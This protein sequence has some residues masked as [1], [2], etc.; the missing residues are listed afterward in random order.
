MD[1]AGLA[2]AH[3]PLPLSLAARDALRRIAWPRGRTPRRAPAGRRP[4]GTLATLHLV[5]GAA[6]D[7]AVHAALEV[8]R[9]FRLR[10]ERVLLVDAGRRIDLHAVFERDPRW[11]FGEVLRGAL[12]L[13]GVVQETGYPGL[14]LLAR[15]A[16]GAEDWSRLA[17]LLDEAAPHFSRVVLALDP[18][19]PRA[20]GEA[21]AGRLVEGWWAGCG[22]L[23]RAA[24]ALAERIGVAF[25][26]LAL[27]QP[28]ERT[29]EILPGLPVAAV[30]LPPG[31]APPAPRPE[32][33]VVAWHLGMRER[34]RFLTWMRRLGAST[35]AG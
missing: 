31:P 15:G 2:G 1:D 13:L 4:A 25:G 27:E 19:C 24:L 30:P 5:S 3:A 8:A 18:A 26:A 22:P 33:E 28:R 9:E 17:R 34:L 29:L 10:A 16:Q 32:P 35:Q 12:P 6:A 7:G 23:P 20:A 21:W 11:G 14:Y